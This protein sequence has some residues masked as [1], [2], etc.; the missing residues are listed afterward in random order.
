MYTQVAVANSGIYV[1][2]AVIKAISATEIES[3]MKSS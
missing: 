1:V 3:M 2:A